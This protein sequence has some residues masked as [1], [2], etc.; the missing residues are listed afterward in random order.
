MEVPF[1]G[2]FTMPF[3]GLGETLVQ[4]FLK[5]VSETWILTKFTVVYGSG[6]FHLII[7]S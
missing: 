5:L 2:N 1:L 3:L 7:K 4:H 6:L